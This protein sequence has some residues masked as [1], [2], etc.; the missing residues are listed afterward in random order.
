VRR[1]V[2]FVLQIVP[3]V[4]YH[5]RTDSS[6]S[7]TS[8]THL[9][10]T[11]ISET[12][13]QVASFSSDGK[14]FNIYDQALF[15]QIFLPQY[16]KHANYGSF[17]RQLNLYGFTSSRMKDQNDIIVW[18]HEYFHRDRKDLLGEI[19][20]AQNSQKKK[21][22]T[23]SADAKP[24]HVHVAR[25]ASPSS[26]EDVS[27]AHQYESDVDHNSLSQGISRQVSGTDHE[28]LESE[29]AYLKQQ[30]IFLEQKLDMLLKITLKISPVSLEEMHA[31]GKRR[32]LY[33]GSSS[34]DWDRNTIHR[35]N[36]DCIH[37]EQKLPEDADCDIEPMPY[38]VNQTLP[39]SASAGSNRQ[40]SMKAFV[41][42]MLSDEEKEEFKNSGS[43]SDCCTNEVANTENVTSAPGR[44]YEDELMAEAM[45]AFL[46][47]GEADGDDL[48]DS[49]SF[50]ENEE[51]PSTHQSAGLASTVSYAV[52]KASGP[53]P[54][55]SSEMQ[56]YNNRG[57]DIEEGGLPIGVTI[58]SA[59]AELVEEDIGA[60][61]DSDDDE[62]KKKHRK[63]VVHL[64]ALI[65]II[66]ASACVIVPSVLL[67]QKDDDGHEEY[68]DASLTITVRPDNKGD[69]P[70]GVSAGRPEESLPSNQEHY[71]YGGEQVIDTTEPEYD[72]D[73]FYKFD[74]NVTE[75]R[76]SIDA[77][78]SYV[79][80][81]GANVSPRIRSDNLFVHGT[82]NF[83]S[84]SVSIEGID[85][86]CN[87]KLPMF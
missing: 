59:H 57:G 5:V 32:R 62:S 55:L 35:H 2:I 20:R 11:N 37:E 10:V 13:P 25:S 70:S 24:T 66:L 42:I 22:A 65:C 63:R 30:N 73:A 85:F 56:V 78:T 9:L 75:V 49:L 83:G 36:L 71:G 76:S 54:V 3:S 74:T 61:A 47:G 67:T 69:V 8:E 15:A 48:L 23:K 26:S 43:D 7:G 81:E 33:P 28:W 50:D 34:G 45:D 64:L 41:D 14:S 58:V 27:S 87:E 82:P 21:T 86:M 68:S 52:D 72:D 29:F 84:F 18:S 31:G 38:Q 19:K 60:K 39:P 46:P 6:L 51:L 1:S 44:N 53:E 16:F 12:D 80:S 17:V 4:L 77:R 79:V 40:E